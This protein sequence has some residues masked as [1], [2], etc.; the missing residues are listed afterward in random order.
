[1]NSFYLFL[2]TLP[3]YSKLS[4]VI[5]NTVQFLKIRSFERLEALK[6]L[7]QFRILFYFFYLNF[8]WILIFFIFLLFLFIF[9]LL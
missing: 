5:A 8:Y 4:F 7:F 9:Y 2:S 3:S 1:M 6:L